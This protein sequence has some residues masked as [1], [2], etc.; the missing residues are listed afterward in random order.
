VQNIAVNIFFIQ[1]LYAMSWKFF[2]S[3]LRDAP[4]LI[5]TLFIAGENPVGI[6]KLSELT[7]SD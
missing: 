3:V 5:N 7:G 4:H 1:Y 2:L 6:Y